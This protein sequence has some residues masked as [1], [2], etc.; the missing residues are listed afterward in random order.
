MRITD[1]PE[2]SPLAQYSNAG[3]SLEIEGT[4][5]QDAT[6][7]S[8]GAYGVETQLNLEPNLFTKLTSRAGNVL[9]LGTLGLSV[10][11]TADVLG[12]EER[13]TILE[14][15]RLATLLAKRNNS[16]GIAIDRAFDYGI[17]SVTP[18]IGPDDDLFE[19]YPLHIRTAIKGIAEGKKDAAIAKEMSWREPGTRYASPKVLAESLIAFRAQEGVISRLGLVHYGHA[20][21]ILSEEW[22]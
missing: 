20:K 12:L 10:V 6:I 15:T 14:R 7:K 18:D 4:N 3:I 21:G 2:F 9:A 22:R 16:F 1:Q 8:I 13:E 11:D 19:I 5:W 17:L